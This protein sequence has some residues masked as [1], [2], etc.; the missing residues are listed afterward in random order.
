[1]TYF[2][3]PPSR[4]AG[5]LR[6]S[7]AVICL[8]F[9]PV[10][11]IDLLGNIGSFH[12]TP[13]LLL[14][15]LYVLLFAFEQVTKRALGLSPPSHRLFDSTS[16]VV[17]FF[18]LLIWTSVLFLSTDTQNLAV[19]RAIYTTW[20]IL[21]A[22]LFVAREQLFLPVIIAWALRIFIICDAISVVIQMIIDLN[23]WPL[24]GVVFGLETSGAKYFFKPSGLVLDA[25]RSSV[26]L[27]LFM[28]LAFLTKVYLKDGKGLGRG[29][30]VLGIIL[31]LIT[32]SRTG[33]ISL[34]IFGTIVFIQ[35][36]RKLKVL[37][38]SLMAMIILGGMSL[39]YLTLTK[40]LSAFVEQ[41]QLALYSSEARQGSTSIHFHL[42][43]NGIGEF[44]GNAKIFLLGAGWGTEYE[45][46]KDFFAD[47]KYGNF[48]CEYVSIAVQT[49]IAGL[50]CVLFLIAKPLLIGLEWKPLTFIILWSCI[51][52]QYH[53]DPFWWIVLMV[54]ST[55]LASRLR[56]HRILI[57]AS[58]WSNQ[59]APP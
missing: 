36:R 19:N 7:F 22:R 20:L 11:V 49:G 43:A 41:A 24:P 53:G 14:S 55:S 5:R 46:T 15:M 13:F 54:M 33:I 56:H 25:N 12:L 35:S 8:V 26:T 42:L 30:Y 6:L 17:A 10:D 29:Y 1:M 58:S 32:I 50:A 21:F 28:G 51:F 59:M 34:A 48:H 4:F 57:S 45:F 23:G 37:G 44:F 31:S 3:S 40:S 27:I 39:L 2:V 38:V 18:I 16:V 52:Y 9:A 47:S